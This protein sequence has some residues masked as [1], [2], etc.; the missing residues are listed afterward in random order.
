MRRITLLLL[1]LTIS[2]FAAFDSYT[3]GTLG[4][5]AVADDASAIWSNPAGLGV[6]RLFNFY[7]SYGGTEDKWSDLSGA[8]QMGCLGLGYQSSSPSLTPDSFLDR[9]SAGMGFGSEDFSLGFSMDWHGEEIADV[10]ES[11]FDMNFGLLWRPMSF[12]SVG[13]TA[14]NIFDDKVDGIA[15]PPSYTGGVAFRP[16]AFDHSL[17]NLLTVSFDVNWSEDPLNTIDDAEQLSWRGGLAIRTIDGLALAFSYDD[18]GFMTAGINIELTNLSLGYGARL[19]DAGEL[20]NHG[21][22]LSYS[23]ERF[24]PLADLSGSEVL[25]LEVGG[26]LHDDPTPF[27]LLGGAKTDLTNLLRDLKRVRRDGDVDA[28]LLRIWSLGGNI[29][30]LTALVQELGKEIELTRAAGISVYAFLAGDGTNTASYYLACYADKIFIPRTID[31]PGLGMAIHV[32]RIGGLAEKYG[33]DLNMITSGDYKSSFH[34]TTKG[35]T[36]VQK[37]AIDELL[38]DLHEQ[39]IT[40][41][42]EQRGLSRTQLEELTDAFSI[43]ALEAKEIG[44]IDEIG[45]YEDALLACSQAG[46]DSAES[47]DSVSTTEVASR[48]YRDEEWGYCPRIAIVGAY[49]SIRSG[50]SG[51]SLLDGSMTMGADTVAAQLDKARLDPHVQA[52]VLRV[53]SGGGSAIASDR[54]AAAVRRLQAD[55]IPVVVSMGDLAASGG[56]WISTPADRVIASGATLT[57]S[58]GVVGMVPSLARLFEEQGIVRESYTRGENADITDYGDQPTA[59]ELALVQQHMDYYYDMFVSGVAEDRGMAADTVEKLAG[60]RVWS[61][62]QALD[63]G[64]IDEIG[65]LRDAIEV[66][67]QL[68]GIDHPTPDLI[69]YGSLG[70]IWLEILSPDLVRLLGFGSLV[71]VDLGL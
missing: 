57:G 17:A 9:F 39:L 28:V 19:T 8:F 7:A 13:A 22:S 15:L 47:F 41:V 26:G 34:Q 3:V 51:R 42:G 35:A 67:R 48:L 54:I 16:L 29:T 6:G 65:G 49:G 5:V 37:Q 53:D 21:A 55:D 60:G 12:I 14:T 11:A 25:T 63:N 32:N 56:Y 23:L 2:S 36:E 70:P 58:I 43:P 31:L 40:V 44:L 33:I 1:V 24:E 46:G 50:E 45:Y 62:Q 71:E 10:K 61:G 20:G 68:G 52:V 64:L 30:P 38:G 27:S 66:A 59:E 18:D 4:S 69:T